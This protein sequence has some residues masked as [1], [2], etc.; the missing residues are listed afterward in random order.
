MQEQIE[1]R[2]K[3]KRP[4]RSRIHRM[5]VRAAAADLWK[6]DPSIPIADMALKD[7]IIEVCEGK[8]YTEK[9]IRNWI[10]DLC[11]IRDPGRRTTGND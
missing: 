10:K 2:D 5:K 3:G 7:E 1:Q 11:P 8:I 4:R 9:I 6:N